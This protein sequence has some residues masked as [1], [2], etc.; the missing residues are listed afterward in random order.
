VS[1]E[2]RIVGIAGSLREGSFNRAL[3]R[4]ATELSPSGVRITPF[5]LEGVPFY[6]A[7]LDEGDLPEPAA[8]LK[9]AISEAD[10]VLIAT[11]EYNY[12]IPGVLKNAIDW[13]SRP[14]YRSPFRDKPV[15]ILGASPSGIGTARAQQHLKLVLLGMAAAVFPWPEV[16][17]AQAMNRIEDGQ[18][19]DDGT[20]EKIEE[21]LAG[22]ADWIRAVRTYGANAK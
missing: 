10:G 11:P 19:K 6:E 18:V 17:V 21:L 3:I 16:A 9:K 20:R 13:A 8:R 12:G 1:E 15:A 2:I 7:S 5:D 22:F 14:G 4:A